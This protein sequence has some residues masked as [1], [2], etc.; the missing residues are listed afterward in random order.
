MYQV[1]EMRT[2]WGRIRRCKVV[3]RIKAVEG[4]TQLLVVDKETDEELRRRQ[5]TCTE[6]MAQRGLPPVHDPWEPKRDWIHSGSLNSE[7]G[8]KDVNGPPRELRPRLCHLRKG[9]QGYGFNLHS[10]KSRPGQYIRSVDLGS[11]A[12]HSGLRAQ[13]RLIEVNGQNVEGLRHAEVV[14]SIKAREDEARLLVVDPETDEYFKR[15]RVTPTEEHVEGPLPSPVTNGTSPTQLNG[16]SAYSSRRDLPG[17]D[18]DNEVASVYPHIGGPKA[19]GVGVCGAVNLGSGAA[20]SK[21]PSW[22]CCPSPT[23]WSLV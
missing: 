2:P 21:K 10:D 23:K 12:A 11:P 14:A 20:D 3:Q 1:L 4:Q 6:E 22:A 5:L 7:A 16:G 18:K 17:L 9:P 15:L 19:F 8:Q 13:D